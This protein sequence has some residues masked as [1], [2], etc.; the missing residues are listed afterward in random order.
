MEPVNTAFDII[1]AIDMFD[2][3]GVVGLADRLYL[4]QNTVHR[5]LVTLVPR[6][7][8]VK[9]TGEHYL[10]L[11][12]LLRGIPAWDKFGFYDLAKGAVNALADRTEGTSGSI[13]RSMAGAAS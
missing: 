11:E 1:E 10:G 8:L 3:G 4:V 2:G 13:P 6:E 12:V 5:H 9:S 7:Y